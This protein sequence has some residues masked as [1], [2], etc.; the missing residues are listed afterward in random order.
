MILALSPQPFQPAVDLT[1]RFYMGCTRILEISSL[2]PSVGVY[3]AQ[4]L[5]APPFV[6]LLP[7]AL[8]VSDALFYHCLTALILS[9]RVSLCH[10]ICLFCQFSGLNYSPFRPPLFLLV[11]LLSIVCLTLRIAITHGFI[12]R[13]SCS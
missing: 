13:Q 9:G 4:A 3:L 1:R 7:I 8:E 11:C 12:D 5:A 6:C 10:A 2:L